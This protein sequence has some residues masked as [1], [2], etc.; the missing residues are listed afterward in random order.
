MKKTLEKVLSIPECADIQVIAGREGLDREVEWFDQVETADGI[1]HS[2]PNYLIFITGVQMFAEEELLTLLREAQRLSISGLI[3]A[4]GGTLIGHIPRTVVEFGNQNQFPVL[5]LPLKSRICD[6]TYPIGRYLLSQAPLRA[7]VTDMLCDVFEGKEIIHD[8]QDLLS[9]LTHAGLYEGRGYRILLYQL[10]FQKE[11][12]SALCHKAKTS[13][14][15]R[16]KG[17]YNGSKLVVPML[18]GVAVIIMNEENT[19][20]QSDA[21][22]CALKHLS[23]DLESAYENA[24]V[25]IG[26]SSVSSSLESIISSYK[27]AQIVVK[28]V[29]SRLQRDNLL[30]EYDKLGIYRIIMECKD[31]DYVKT[32]KKE[33][34]DAL[35][36]YDQINGTD[37]TSFLETYF[38]CNCNVKKVSETAYLHKNTVLYK[39]KKIEGILHCDFNHIDDMLDLRMALLIRSIY[40]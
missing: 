33:K 13:L 6:Y 31:Q 7:T 14:M 17:I 12:D 5:E 21:L 30:Y 24:E 32:F 16:V 36:A 11:P 40:G 1:C 28:L 2:R 4:P 27:K 37:L 18:F 9:A 38:Q 34:F 29:T 26:I 39:Q 35:E 20:L 3:I 23:E 8:N 10:S 25:R 15:N 19:S 22:I